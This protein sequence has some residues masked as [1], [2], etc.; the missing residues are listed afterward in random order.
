MD[1]PDAQRWFADYLAEFVA[2]ARGDIA[3]PRRILDHYGVPMLVSTGD[4]TLF[5]ADDEQVLGM[6]GRQLDGMRGAGYDRTEQLSA[7]TTL[8]NATCALHR[9]RFA[10]L[11]ADG[12]EITRVEV[13]YVIT[14]GSAGPRISA[15]LV[16]SGQ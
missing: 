10:W 12:S 4:G 1:K 6:I 16:H 11:R 3:D 5:L 14:E 9:G 8:L 2:L 13:S 15:L 7:E